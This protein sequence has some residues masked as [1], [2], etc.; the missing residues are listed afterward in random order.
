MCSTP[1]QTPARTHP[2]QPHIFDKRWPHSARVQ[3]AK[4]PSVTL[5]LCPVVL[6]GLLR[7]GSQARTEGMTTRAESCQRSPKP[8]SVHPPRCRSHELR[9]HDPSTVRRLSANTDASS[10]SFG[11]ETSRRC[12]HPTGESSNAS[13]NKEGGRGESG[14]A[15]QYRKGCL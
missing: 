5:L 1:T 13:E 7:Q 8:A 4:V 14:R 3:Q 2:H 15:D 12:R 10:R 6:T 11:P 9:L